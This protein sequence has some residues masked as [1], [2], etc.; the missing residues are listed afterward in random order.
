MIT[1]RDGDGNERERLDLLRRHQTDVTAQIQ[2]PGTT[3]VT[4]AR[5][6]Y[7]AR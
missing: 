4:E 5:F 3:A 1:V 6:D 7:K 2:R